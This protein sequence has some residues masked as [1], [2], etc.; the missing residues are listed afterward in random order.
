M[1]Q[2]LLVFT[3]FLA[4]QASAQIKD[5][6]TVCFDGPPREAV[7]NLDVQ[8]EIQSSRGTTPIESLLK[9]DGTINIW[10]DQKTGYVVT[11]NGCS[12]SK[13]DLDFSIAPMAARAQLLTLDKIVKDPCAKGSHGEQIYRVFYTSLYNERPEMGSLTVYQATQSTCEATR[14]TGPNPI[15]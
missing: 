15:F 3:T 10:L 13:F 14:I 11:D 7:M 8:K 1:N 2:L 4:F 9:V 5:A 12:Q 6:A